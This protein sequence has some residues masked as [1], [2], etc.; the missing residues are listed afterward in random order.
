MKGRPIKL[1]TIK[2]LTCFINFSAGEAARAAA[3]IHRSRHVAGGVFCRGRFPEAQYDP[4]CGQQVI[5][6]ALKLIRSVCLAPR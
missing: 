1:S 3:G 2:P 6:C 4:A 5:T